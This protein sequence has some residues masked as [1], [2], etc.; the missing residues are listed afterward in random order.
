M[1]DTLVV[2]HDERATV[3]SS[4]P[5]APWLPI[6]STA[7]T[8]LGGSVPRPMGLVR[9]LVQVDGRLFCTRRDGSGKL[10]LPTAYV[11][12][13]DPDGSVAIAA[14]M[15]RVTGGGQVPRYLG[16][17]RN[18]VPRPS[19]GYDWPTPVAYF[20][21]WTTDADPVVPGEWLHSGP[22]SVLA[23]RHWFPLLSMGDQ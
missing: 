21:V 9:L 6:G 5:D 15:R 3:V 8:L 18:T 7:E 17:V 13:D 10:D 20:G 22:P 16:A 23:E 14:L 2:M 4:T 12:T 19:P 1:V 11:G